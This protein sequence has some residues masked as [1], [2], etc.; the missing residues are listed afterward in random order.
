MKIEIR[1]NTTSVNNA[2]KQLERAKKG[3]ILAYEATLEEIAIWLIERANM[4]L[5]V[6]SI[7]DNVKI[8][9]RNAWIYE[10]TAM[11]MKITN[12]SDKA[13]FVEFGVGIVGL[14][15]QHIM[16]SREGYQYNIGSKIREDGTWV[17]STESDDDIDI[18]ARY[19][20]KR[21][22]TTVLTKGQPA[23]MY[24]Y[25][26]IVDLK[27]GNTIKNIWQKNKQRYIG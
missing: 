7:G 26:A 23:V 25:N 13:S 2:I 3:V 17:F 11:G 9:I 16:A 21:T 20:L 5:N 1:L 4:H 10:R 14:E 22:D 8:D 19:V 18:Q 15:N 27:S 12:Q 6:S 24:A